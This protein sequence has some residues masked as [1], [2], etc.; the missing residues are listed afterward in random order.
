MALSALDTVKAI[1]SDL[2]SGMTDEQIGLF[3]TMA[4]E[5]VDSCIWGSL[6]TQAVAN[7][8][9]HLISVYTVR[10]AASAGGGG[11][12]TGPVTMEIAGRVTIQYA[13]PKD[14]ENNA[15]RL[16]PW[17]QE[18]DRLAKKLP[19]RHMFNT[20]FRDSDMCDPQPGFFG[21]DNSI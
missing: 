6:F 14:W 12:G 9:A 1:A 4:V 15:L 17:G 2:V 8:S 10:A 11:G 21:E 13:S 3:I 20:G 5:Q 7:L 18:L 19:G 16:T